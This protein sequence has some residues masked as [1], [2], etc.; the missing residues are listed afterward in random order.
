MDSFVNF[1]AMPGL[2]DTA[3]ACVLE[4][5]NCARPGEAIGTDGNK[6]V[7]KSPRHRRDYFAAAVEVAPPLLQAL[8]AIAA[9]VGLTFIG[10]H[11]V[12]VWSIVVILSLSALA[13]FASS[14]WSWR[15]RHLLIDR[16]ARGKSGPKTRWKPNARAWLVTGSAVTL[17]LI[18]LSIYVFINGIEPNPN[19]SSPYD[20]LDPQQSPCVNSAQQIKIAEPA[21]LDP[22]KQVVGQV[23]LVRSVNCATVWAR[24]TL[25]KQAAQRLKSYTV[26]IVMIRPGDGI[27]APFSIPLGGATVAYGSMLS[28]TQACVIAK[29]S[30]TSSQSGERGP[31]AATPCK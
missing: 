4:F 1:A 12:P 19:Y 26:T 2:E 15:A 11:Y 8:A 9:T 7:S 10:H 27:K 18:A 14:I 25:T 3:G 22:A 17:S 24:V 28:D 13:L 6:M 29:V 23:E 21:L 31:E 20:G 30:L 16:E 5:R